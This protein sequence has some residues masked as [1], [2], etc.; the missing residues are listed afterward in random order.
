MENQPDKRIKTLKKQ[1][2]ASFLVAIVLIFAGSLG[3]YSGWHQIKRPVFIIVGFDSPV[4]Q[5]KKP[6]D[7]TSDQISDLVRAFKK[8]DYQAISPNDLSDNFYKKQSGRS[9]LMTFASFTPETIAIADIL[10]KNEGISPIIFLD[11]SSLQKSEMITQIQSSE[12]FF[13]GFHHNT[14]I[15]SREK[16]QKITGDKPLLILKQNSESSAGQSELNEKAV[17]FFY[18]PREAI[19]GSETRFLPV[20]KYVKGASEAGMPDIKDWLPPD[21]A[22]K[23]KLTITLSLLLYFIS[24]SWFLRSWNMISSAAKL[25]NAEEKQSSL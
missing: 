11:D 6:G 25:K 17:F 23:G 16:A 13:L 18:A 9:F 2:L 1:S 12:S 3:F 10:F 15:S 5:P 22:R 14:W 19:N 7:I 24:L 21:S 8:N 4:N 20:I